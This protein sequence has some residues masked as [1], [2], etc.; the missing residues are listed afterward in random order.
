MHNEKGSIQPFQFQSPERRTHHMTQLLGGE[1][2]LHAQDMWSLGEVIKE[3]YN[4]DVPQ[5]GKQHF[6]SCFTFISSA[7]PLLD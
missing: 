2:P 3:A 4:K 6:I 1:C 7:I 5:N